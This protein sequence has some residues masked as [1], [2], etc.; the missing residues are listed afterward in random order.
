MVCI[1]TSCV[2]LAMCMCSLQD[3]EGHVASD[4][5]Y[6]APELELVD[7]DAVAASSAATDEL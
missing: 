7:E 2:D 4:F 5:D 3:N 6:K 1:Y